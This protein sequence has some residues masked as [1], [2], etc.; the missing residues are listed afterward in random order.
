MALQQPFSKTLVTNPIAPSSNADPVATHYDT[1][2][3]GGWMS[4]P[5]TTERDLIPESR[6]KWGMVV[7]TINNGQVYMLRNVNMNS[8]GIAQGINGS[9]TQESG[10]PEGWGGSDLMDNANWVLFNF[11]TSSGATGATGPTG[12]SGTN[13]PQGPQG[14]QGVQGPANLPTV[15][16]GV[17][18]VQSA[19]GTAGATAAFMWSG[20]ALNIGGN[21][22]G[23]AP[24]H[25]RTAGAGDTAIRVDGSDGNPTFLLKGDG[26]IF[27][28]SVNSF[29]TNQPF[30][31]FSTL[32]GYN[33]VNQANVLIGGNQSYYGN[34]T[35]EYAVRFNN[36][37]YGSNASG[38][39][40]NLYE[41]V[42]KAIPGPGSTAQVNGLNI[43]IEMG[44]RLGLTGNGT[45]TV[46]ATGDIP[47]V[48]T[49][50]MVQAAGLP[51]GLTVTSV[52]T[53]SLTLSS[54]APTGQ[55]F[56]EIGYP[57]TRSIFKV[58]S[59]TNLST[60]SSSGGALGFRA[61]YRIFDL[62]DSVL[63]VEIGG[64]GY[65]GIL[66]FG[67]SGYGI[68]TNASHYFN[69]GS[70]NFPGNTARP[71]FS[72]FVVGYGNTFS[73]TSTVIGSNNRTTNDIDDEN[74]MS[75]VFGNSNDV[76][77]GSWVFGKFSKVGSNAIV[78]SPS[79][80]GTNIY[81]A[82]AAYSV[83][84]TSYPYTGTFLDLTNG[85]ATGTPTSFGY[86]SF[87][88]TLYSTFGQTGGLGQ[89]SGLTLTSRNIPHYW[90]ANFAICYALS[91]YTSGSNTV[92]GA[93]ITPGNTATLVANTLANAGTVDWLNGSTGFPSYGTGSG[94]LPG[95]IIAIGQGD[96]VGATS[97]YQYRRVVT[98]SATA[99]TLNQG[100]TAPLTGGYSAGGV[101]GTGQ[102]LSIFGPLEF[103]RVR[104]LGGRTLY[105]INGHGSVVIGPVTG[106]TNHHSRGSG[107]LNIA[108]IDQ[109]NWTFDSDIVG[110]GGPVKP[111]IVFSKPISGSGPSVDVTGGSPG[112]ALREGSMWYNGKGLKFF[113]GTT[114]MNLLL[115]GGA[116]NPPA[117][118]AASA[119]ALLIGGA[120]VFLGAP[121][122][123]MLVQ[124]ENQNYFKLPLY[125]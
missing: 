28:N 75:Y 6:R 44:I 107:W 3:G 47:D 27:T 8:S 26:S 4:V 110:I 92:G 58:R 105:S 93:Y 31:N 23:A 120:S 25:I 72:T 63:G 49:G 108:P 46:A 96:A 111:Q 14:P 60:S 79:N 54:A 84:R 125:S 112:G 67:Q 7:V 114:G 2:G 66:G 5:T 38:G 91:G 102:L 35:S 33:S 99:I 55:Y 39:L 76:G 109:Y 1:L 103:Y 116:V 20:T 71:A 50:M 68:P 90:G 51:M 48:S 117:T 56:A 115:S 34:F 64:V 100:L 53:T 86:M 62:S 69:V 16:G 21:T 124:D 73:S 30:I 19:P 12:N 83:T 78:F 15:T 80:F 77:P 122:S 24:L 36:K 40:L 113:N 106:T 98:V 119:P 52:G 97:N 18:F 101:G 11:N 59:A 10:Y 61:G 94:I 17:L 42:G 118:A 74:Q 37:L 89:V 85:T 88:P 43:S 22:Y 81:D 95:S 32:A 45:T 29:A 82:N 65:T 123:W 87:A 104:D 13:G 41:F 121:T 9:F 57:G 70:S